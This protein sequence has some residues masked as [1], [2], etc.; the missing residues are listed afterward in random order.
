MFEFE[1]VGGGGVRYSMGLYVTLRSCAVQI[2]YNGGDGS[3]LVILIGCMELMVMYWPHSDKQLV[4]LFD[5][6]LEFE[7]V[8]V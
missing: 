1:G 3:L 7:G 8:D 5:Y 4:R 6:V 2:Q